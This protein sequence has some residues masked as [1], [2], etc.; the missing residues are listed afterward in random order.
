MSRSTLNLS[1]KFCSKTLEVLQ[2]ERQ[3]MFY[4]NSLNNFT[5]ISRTN[6]AKLIQISKIEGLKLTIYKFSFQLLI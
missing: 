4:A 6:D 5:K 3:S 2:L 1:I